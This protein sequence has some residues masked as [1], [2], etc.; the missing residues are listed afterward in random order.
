MKPKGEFVRKL[1]NHMHITAKSRIRVKTITAAATILFAFTSVAHANVKVR[2]TSINFGT[3]AIGSKSSQT[4]ILT[5]ESNRRQVTISSEITS[6]PQFTYSGPALPV[7]LNPGQSLTGVVIFAP[8]SAVAYSGT[9]K[10]TQS[11]GAAISMGLSG[12]GSGVTTPPAAAVAPSI[13]TQP[14]NASILAGQTATFNI[15]ATGTSPMTYQW[16]KNG[17]AVSG[18][19][20]SSY[21]TPAETT[22]DNNA[23]FT[24]AV[25]NSVGSA[26]SNAAMLT[27]TNPVVAPSITS[28]PASQTVVAGK[29]A[30]FAVAATG[31]TPMTYQWS[32]NGAAISGATS[33]SYTTPAEIT[34]DNNAKF[35]VA[36]SN[37]AGS[38][39]SNA[40]T[41]TVTSATVAPAITTQ[42]ASQSVIAGKTASF[43]VTASG[44]T[45]MTYQWSKNGTAISGATS[46]TYTTPAEITADNNAQFTVAVSNSAGSATSSAAVLT[47]TASTLLLNSSTSSVSF[48]SVN[49]SSS[50]TQNV[51]LTNAGNSTVTISNVTVSGPGFNVSGVSSGLIM[52][53]GQTATLAATFSPSTAGSAAGSVSVASNATNSPDAITLS[54]TGVAVVSH[55]V[56]LGWSAS[57]STV[58]GYNTYASNVSGGPYT[59][60]TTAPVSTLSYTDSSVV[61]GQTYYFVVTAVTSSNVESAYSVEVSALVP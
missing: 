29:T 43:S 25:G 21:T 46:A 37:S 12:V 53:P 31:T 3:D 41:L 5:N 24:V 58:V 19:T 42:P 17:V 40:A 34:A 18:A 2:P 35:T 11:N 7:T 22:A 32:K 14:S 33:S 26:T 1:G 55:S 15:A 49:V 4:V 47:V 13:S 56:S 10:F 50:G 27:V 52:T 36:V 23:K 48:G 30:S 6:D 59:K 16:S 60:L 51:T 57:A 44:T 45:P 38:A 9:L 61:S 8:T 54:G 39:T 28:Q 20:S